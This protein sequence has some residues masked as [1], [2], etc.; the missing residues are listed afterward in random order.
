MIPALLG[1]RTPN[2]TLPISQPTLPDFASYAKELEAIFASRQITNDRWVRRLEEQA[3]D[4]LGVCDVVAVSSATSG[5]MLVA[6]LLGL[7]G[8]A[9][10]PSFTF[11]ATLHGSAPPAL[12]AGFHHCSCTGE[13]WAASSTATIP[14]REWSASVT[15]RARYA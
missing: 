9:L 12:R 4:Y 15:A 6:K 11:P 13:G 1:G 8:K 5:M 10:L 14:N 2:E 3:A 7:R